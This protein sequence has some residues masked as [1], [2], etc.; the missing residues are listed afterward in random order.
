MV[1]APPPCLSFTQK[2]VL[3]SWEGVWQR[4]GAEPLEVGGGGGQVTVR[5]RRAAYEV[6]RGEF[7]GPMVCGECQQPGTGAGVG[8]RR[9]PLQVWEGWTQWPHNVL[10][11]GCRLSLRSHGTPSPPRF[12]SSCSFFLH[13]PNLLRFG[14]FHRGVPEAL[15]RVAGSIVPRL[16]VQGAR[17]VQ[18]LALLYPPPVFSRKP[19]PF[20]ESFLEP[21][22]RKRT[23]FILDSS[24]SPFRQLLPEIPQTGWLIINNRSLFLPVRA[25]DPGSRCW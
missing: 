2:V 4:Q 7:M 20:P 24:S 14:P 12:P 6:K 16:C 3:E 18:V 8:Q 25:G 22:Q 10:P 23:P 19:T 17:A 15:S 1:S 21:H 5:G 11:P 13:F 9:C